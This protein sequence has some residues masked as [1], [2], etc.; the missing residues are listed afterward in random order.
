MKKLFLLLI[1]YI[2]SMPISYSLCPVEEGESVCTLPMDTTQVVPLFTN[3]NAGTAMTNTQL[4]LQPFSQEN[5][6][7]MMRGQNSELNYNSG[8]QFGTCL[9][10]P[11]QNRLP[12]NSEL[13]N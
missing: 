8:C 5:P 11:N 1:L 10:N 2:V 13:G 3:P 9:Q 6:E 7:A 4:N 12:L